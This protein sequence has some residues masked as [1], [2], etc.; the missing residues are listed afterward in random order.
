MKT[1]FGRVVALIM[2][3]VLLCA[4]LP[5][6]IVQVSAASN[7]LFPVKDGRLAYY[8]GYSASYGGTHS[9]ID[10]HA[11]GSD[12]I[13]AAYSGTVD[14]ATDPC[15]HTDWAKNHSTDCGHYNTFGNYIRIKQDDGKYAYYGHLLQGSLLVSSGTYV[16]KGQPIARMGS[17]GASTGKH[18]HFEVRNST[19]TSDT[20]NVNPTSAG[21]S[22]EYSYSGYDGE[23]SITYSTIPTGQYYLWNH[24]SGQYL[25]IEGSIDAQKQNAGVYTFTGESG[26]QMEI[27]SEANGHRIRPL[28][29]AER[30]LNVAADVVSPGV[31]VNLYDNTRDSSQRWGFESKGDGYYV[32]RS[33]N[34]PSCVLAQS[35]NNAE[36]QL[37]TGANNQIWGL[38]TTDDQAPTITNVDVTDID[39][40]GYT[41]TC[42]VA[43][44]AGVIRVDFPTWTDRNGQ[45]D[46]LWRDGTISGSTASFFVSV[47]DHDREYGSYITHIY[48]YDAA[49][50]ASQAGLVVTVS[51]LGKPRVTATLNGHGYAF[52]DNHVS[53]IAACRYSEQLGGHLVTI[54]SAEE[55]ALLERYINNRIYWIGATDRNTEG[56]WQ[57]VTGEEWDYTNW[58]PSQPDNSSEEEYAHLQTT[59]MWNDEDNTVYSLTPGF[60]VEYDQAAI[61]LMEYDRID[62]NEAAQVKKQTD[63]SWLIETD[64]ATDIGIVGNGVYE[65]DTFQYLHLAITSDVPFSVS[66]YDMANGRWMTSSGDFYPDFGLETTGQTISAGSYVVSLWTNGCYTW[67]GDPLPEQVSLNSIYITTAD[68]GRL[69][70]SHMELS[71]F[72]GCSVDAPQLRPKNE[73]TLGDVIKDNTVNTFDALVLYAAMSGARVLSDE[74]REVADINGDGVVNM[75]DAVKLYQQ[76][77]GK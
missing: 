52:Y 47:E 37:Y 26:M 76:V 41:V 36:V 60:I 22:V 77:S 64:E 19:S 42:T 28:C 63:G 57:W 3:V 35:G 10:I 20:Y 69:V 8:Y 30:S 15:G 48:A 43:D 2:S 50:N 58:E 31:N 7:Y 73:G 18:L 25:V 33:M 16:R 40:T 75:F 5:M 65:A 53:W 11:T 9:G 39:G 72:E 68:A 12:V 4:M 59:G 46:L 70:V 1:C 34:N 29:S 24:G 23:V 32:I 38:R 67:Q 21:G 55:Q 49:G 44:N 56:V 27:T 6:G 13:Y 51:P 14:R 74:Q 62:A 54:N 61:D 71:R 66:F 45:D 17:S